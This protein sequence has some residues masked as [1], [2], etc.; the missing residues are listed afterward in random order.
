MRRWALSAVL[1]GAAL[2]GGPAGVAISAARAPAARAHA[3]AARTAVTAAGNRRLARFDAARLLTRLQLPPGSVPSA[4]EPAGDR[5]VLRSAAV[6]PSG[7]L[8]DRHGFWIVPES[9]GAVDAYALAHP[10]RGSVQ[11]Q[12]GSIDNPGGQNGA[13]EGFGWPAILDRLSTRQLVFVMTSLASG[14]TGVR[15]DAQDLWITPRPRSERI[16]A[17]TDRMVVE[18]RRFGKLVDGPFAFSGRRRIGRT[19]ALINA[20]PLAQPWAYACP[21]DSGFVV[22]LT[23]L[24][25]GRV[26]PVAVVS[27]DPQGCNGV[28]LTLG[29]RAQPPL[30][31][32][33]FPG[34]GLSMRH[35]LIDELDAALGLRLASELR[36]MS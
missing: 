9:V 5:G 3:G 15:V 31:S 17:R 7:T 35:P 8:V 32:L 34:S 21:A 2:V 26:Q 18:M 22:R 27:V 24:A 10:A 11:N 1:C 23:F 14:R 13:I 36:R 29:G 25:A 19:T 4:S 20:L 16:R 12:S 6:R 30:T 28:G 33:P